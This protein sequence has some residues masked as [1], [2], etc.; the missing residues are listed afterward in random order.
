MI[1]YFITRNYNITAEPFKQ[2]IIVFYILAG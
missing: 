1:I 2:S